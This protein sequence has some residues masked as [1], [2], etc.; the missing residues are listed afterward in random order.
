M[1]SS[2]ILALFDQWNSC[3]QTGEPEK[4]VI[5]GGN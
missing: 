2:Q 1:S 3:L 5:K 4:I